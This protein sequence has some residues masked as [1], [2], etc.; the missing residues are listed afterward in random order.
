MAKYFVIFI[1]RWCLLSGVFIY[2]AF[3]FFNISI[4]DRILIIKFILE[5]FFFNLTIFRRVCWLTQCLSHLNV[6]QSKTV[7]W[8]SSRELVV[9]E[10]IKAPGEVW[11]FDF[12]KNSVISYS[13]NHWSKVRLIK[14]RV[15]W[16][17]KPFRFFPL[18]EF[19][20]FSCS[21]NGGWVGYIFKFTLTSG[22][23]VIS[24]RCAGYILDFFTILKSSDCFCFFLSFFDAFFKHLFRWAF[25]L[26]IHKKTFCF[27]L[28]SV[29]SSD[30]LS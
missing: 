10:Q 25:F 17:M 29:G 15:I 30:G 20:N 8:T 1:F 3:I 12:R 24:P 5:R 19:V 21:S 23:P 18:L 27:C 16:C 26:Y 4:P 22:I 2:A 9:W 13:N 14:L 28:S 7:W 6:F 11:Y